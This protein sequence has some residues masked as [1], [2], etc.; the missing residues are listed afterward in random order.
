MWVIISVWII[1]H[2]TKMEKR[3][4]ER[5]TER[6]GK[7]KV[8]FI[9]LSQMTKNNFVQQ[10]NWRKYMLLQFETS[11]DE[12]VYFV[13]KC[14][15]EC[16]PDTIHTYTR[17]YPVFVTARCIRAYSYARTLVFWNVFSETSFFIASREVPLCQIVRFF[18]AHFPPLTY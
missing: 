11:T 9:Y 7:N 4:G 8:D 18:R 16:A 1:F 15:G 6:K 13:A 3:E 14:P 17:I 2:F 12:M 10:S 5:K